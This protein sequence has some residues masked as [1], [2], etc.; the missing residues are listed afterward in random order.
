[1]NTPTHIICGACLAQA[2]AQIFSCRKMDSPRIA[3]I[4]AGAFGLGVI[5]HLLLDM[6]PHYAWVVYLDWFKP[7]PFHWLIREAMFGLAVAI[8][9]F[10]LSGRLWPYAAIGMLGAIY[11]DVEKVLSVDFHVPDQFILFGWHSNYLSNRT[12]GLPIPVL[13]GLELV[14][15][16]GFL[17]AMWRMKKIASNNRLQAIG[18]KTRLQPEP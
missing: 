11:P 6:L 15:I 8:P 5:S 7:L 18:A 16:T 17:Y 14:L 1:M 4:M 2:L 13:I 10:I 12:L 9:A 3:A